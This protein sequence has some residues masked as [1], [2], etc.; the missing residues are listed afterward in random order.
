M[1]TTVNLL[2]MMMSKCQNPQCLLWTWLWSVVMR[3]TC[4][5]V[6]L[7]D[8]S[9]WRAH[10]VSVVC[11]FC[12]HQSETMEQI[13]THMKVPGIFRTP[14]KECLEM[15]MKQRNNKMKNLLRRTCCCFFSPSP[16]GSWF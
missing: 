16:G 3:F 1:K 9:D 15:Q 11:L 10:P 8:W 7:S 4:G 2:K 5:L 6:V 12:D 14:D 13:Y